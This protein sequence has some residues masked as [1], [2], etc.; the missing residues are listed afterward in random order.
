MK[1]GVAILGLGTSGFAAARLALHQGESVYVSELRTDPPTH[2]RARELRELGARVDLGEH[3][4]ALL[5]KAGMV[6]VSPGIPP[7]APVLRRLHQEGVHWVSEPEFA[8]RLYKGPLI[9]VTGTNG[10]TTTACLVAHLLT[11]AKLPAALGGNVGEEL[12]PAASDLALLDPPPRWYVLEL[13]SFQLAGVQT[14]APR[15]GVV[16]T[17]APDHL[18]RYPDVESYYADKARLF[19]NATDQ[20]WWVLNGESEAVRALPG[21]A[22]GRRAYAARDGAQ[23]RGGEAAAFLH[24]GVLTL[25]LPWGN[26]GRSQ[27]EGEGSA[28]RTVSLLPASQLSLLGGHNHLNALLAALTARLAGASPEAI[29]Q[30]LA[31]FQPLPHRM[32]PVARVD[33]VTWV[34][35]SKATNVQASASAIQSL[36]APV[37]VLLGGKDKGESFGPLLEPL[38]GRARAVVLFGQAASRLEEEL[39]RGTDPTFELR[40]TPGN[41][42][43]EAVQEAASLAQDGDVV[44][45]SPA[46]SSFDAFQDYRARGEAFTRI[47]RGRMGVGRDQ[48]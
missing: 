37:V 36:D 31:T 42:L 39:R 7:D 11:T 10:K 15:I 34:N 43:A 3:D 26:D 6:V 1:A 14:L 28:A 25:Q 18:D 27:A 24:D 20:N 4:L 45:L 47:V 48:P 8:A 21:R 19:L 22:P 32:E 40:R 23:A 12:A 9:G 17:L 2:E 46:C 44:L 38:R 29:R 5:A 16:T 35:D 13:S 33:G 41:S 30:G